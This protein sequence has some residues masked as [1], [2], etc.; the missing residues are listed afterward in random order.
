MLP[1]SELKYTGTMEKPAQLD[2][3]LQVHRAD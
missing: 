3:R 2:S 1:M